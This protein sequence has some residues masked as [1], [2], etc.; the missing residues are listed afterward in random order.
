MKATSKMLR[1]W[2]KKGRKKIEMKVWDNFLQFL[3]KHSIDKV[4]FCT[5]IY[6]TFDFAWPSEITLFFYNFFPFRGVILYAL[7]A[8]PVIWNLAHK[9]LAR[10][11]KPLFPYDLYL[12]VWFIYYFASFTANDNFDQFFIIILHLFAWNGT[13]YQQI[14]HLLNI[15]PLFN[16]ST[17]LSIPSN[18]VLLIIA[19]SVFNITIECLINDSFFIDTF[20]RSASVTSSATIW[21]SQSMY[22]SIN[23]LQDSHLFPETISI[24]QSIKYFDLFLSHVNL[25]I[26]PISILIDTIHYFVF[27]DQMV[28]QTEFK[29]STPENWHLYK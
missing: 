25:I 23:M 4:L 12:I 10:N 8:T 29:Y 24:F 13:F 5:C 26:V 11:K 9:F 21:T 27:L 20:K 2:S 28:L 7:L 17:F 18:L 15:L 16:Y 14:L 3:T 1:F 6:L 22:S 19:F